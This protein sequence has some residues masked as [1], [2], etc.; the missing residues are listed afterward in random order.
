[1]GSMPLRV[2]TWWVAAERRWFN[3]GF[4]LGLFLLANIAAMD[5]A[6]MISPRE[7]LIGEM[8]MDTDM[9]GRPCADVLYL[10]CSP[11]HPAGCWRECRAVHPGG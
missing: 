7:F 3:C 5:E 9:A 1:M 4:Q 6:P 11:F 2:W 10:E 8:V